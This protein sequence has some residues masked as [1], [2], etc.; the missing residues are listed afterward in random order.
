MTRVSAS[1]P[2]IDTKKKRD[3]KLHT[4][5]YSHV[6]LRAR[7]TPYFG[8]GSGRSRVPVGNSALPMTCRLLLVSGREALSSSVL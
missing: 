5:A 8:Y 1:L 6:F 7:D 4:V 3:S 2:P